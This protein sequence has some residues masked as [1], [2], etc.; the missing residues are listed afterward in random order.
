MRIG[1][2]FRRVDRLF[3]R[4]FD[5]IGLGNAHAQVLLCLLQEGELRVVDVA[6]LTGFEASTVSRLTRE[7]G[8]RK[9]IHRRH[10][11][12]DGRVRLLRPAKR[13]LALRGDLVRLQARVNFRLRRDLTEAD[14]EGCLRTMAAL[15]RLP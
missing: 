6:A 4:T 14:L 1:S 8:R 7:L 13:G 5:A 3:N 2:A 12:H 10:D 15:D 9:L 11:P